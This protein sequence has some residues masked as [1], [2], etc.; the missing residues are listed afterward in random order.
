M[1]QSS[2]YFY[3]AINL[4]N[5]TIQQGSIYFDILDTEFVLY[6]SHLSPLIFQEIHNLLLVPGVAVVSNKSIA[7]A[8]TN[9]HKLVFQTCNSIKQ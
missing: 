5:Y 3:A 7:K 2:I 8:V 9:G 4:N 1:Q 6:S